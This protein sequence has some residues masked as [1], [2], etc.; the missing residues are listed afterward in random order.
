MSSVGLFSPRGQ[1]P[2]LKYC[3][4][5]LNCASLTLIASARSAWSTVGLLGVVLVD[6]DAAVDVCVDAVV[7]VVD[8]ADVAVVTG[9]V[10][11][12]SPGAVQAPIA[13]AAA[14]A[15]AV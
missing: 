4:S 13:S 8:A 15:I 2:S 11:C 5:S 7:G 3:C 10:V 9:V 12:S 6:G 1:P 14:M